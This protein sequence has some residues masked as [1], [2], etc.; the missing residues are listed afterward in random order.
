[1]KAGFVIFWVAGLL[2]VALIAARI[3]PSDYIAGRA[4]DEQ[5][6]SQRNHSALALMLGEFRTSISDMMF[7]KTERYLHGG[8][9]F[10]GNC[11]AT[12]LSSERMVEGV[13]AHQHEAGES[14]DEHHEHEAMQ[15]LIPAAEH[16]FR[17]FVGWLHREVKPWQDPAKPHIHADGRELLPWFRLMTVNDPHYVRGY[18]AGGF[19]LQRQGI[20]P[21]L[22]FINEGIQN[23]PLAFQLYVSRG[24]LLLKDARSHRNAIVE[25]LA[26]EERSVLTSA[27]KD[28][29]HAV[30][31]ARNQRPEGLSEADLERGGEWGLYQENDAMAACSMSVTLTRRLGDPSAAVALARR[32]LEW[33]PATVSL[34]KEIENATN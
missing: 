11:E 26:D 13:G 2:V 10:V 22:V 20:D 1:M 9:G 3:D 12:E 31:L 27:L 28:F 16:D 29:L 6:R 4:R 21:A 25:T 7:V 17:G 18:V 23:N 24:F 19:W 8:I 15:T 32:Y 30:E 33:L 5:E 34:Q 14:N